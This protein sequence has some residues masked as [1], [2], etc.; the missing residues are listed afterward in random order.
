MS[1]LARDLRETVRRFARRPAFVG[2]VVLTLGIGIGS[3]TTIF[4]VIDAVVFRPL[5]FPDPDRLVNLFETT[6]EGRDFATSEPN[7]LDFQRANRSFVGLAAF[8]GDE[9]ALVSVDGEPVS[10]QAAAVSA[11][12]F[13]I[14]ETRTVAGRTFLPAED[15]PGGDQTVVVLSHGLWQRRFGGNP[16]VVGTTISLSDRPHQ[17]IGILEPDFDFPP[18]VEIWVPL[19]PRPDGSRGHHD[20]SLIGRLAPGVSQTMAR[21]ELMTIASE[22]GTTHPDTNQDWGVRIESLRDAIVGPDLDRRM[23]VILGAVGLLLLIACVNVSNLL[24]AQGLERRPELAVRAA[25]GARR[26]VLLR[27]LITESLC[28]SIAGASLGLLIASWAIPLIQRLNPGGVARLDEAAL[29]ARVFAFTTVVALATGILFGLIPATRILSG[30]LTQSLGQGG[31]RVA[32]G[33]RLR[34]ALVVVELALAMTLLLG[35]TL[36]GRSFIQLL[37]TDLGIDTEHVVAVPLTLPATRY[38][39]DSRLAFYGQ[40]ETGLRALPGVDQVSATNVLPIGGGS[41][42]MGVVVDGRAPN[43]SEEGRFADWRA[44][45]PGIFETL[46]VPLLRGRGFQ[47]ADVGAEQPVVVISQGLAERLLPGE[48]PLGERLALWEDPERLHTIIGVVADLNDIQL[49][50][51]SRQTVYFPDSGGWPWMTLLVRTRADLATIA[52]PVRQAIWDVDPALPVP[53]IET[54]DE[55]KSAAAAPQRFGFWARHQHQ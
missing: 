18:T 28:L 52:G 7:F 40:I 24:L 44:V 12:L 23:S 49:D 48:D 55:R 53:T 4:S 46:G 29:D 27:T 13:D 17:V 5:P 38:T 45:R 41:T 15:V 20:L 50:G 31:R 42:V 9:L 35:A 22:L 30:N 2:L 21:D 25:L 33:S 47:A 43:A 3:T 26:P 8:R 36:L 1:Q 37:D 34:D 39:L 10:L 16:A 54:L 11:S 51:G 14:L 6:P 32:P 19:Q